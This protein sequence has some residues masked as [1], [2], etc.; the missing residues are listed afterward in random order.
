MR[1]VT[2]NVDQITGTSAQFQEMFS[3]YIGANYV[4]TDLLEAD[5][6]YIG[7]LST[8]VIE[9]GEDSITTI[10]E[11]TI[12]TENVVAALVSGESGSFDTLTSNS[13][14]IEYLNSGIIEAGSISVDDLKA[15]LATI[16]TLAADSAFVSYLQNLSSTTAQATITEAYI[17]NAVAGHIS[18]ADL[19]THT[20]SAQQIVLISA[21]GTHPAIA[22]QNAT[23]QFY[24]DDG[25][26]RV[27]IGQDSNGDFNFIVRGS[28][29]TTALFNEN[30]IT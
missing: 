30:G 14:F 3:Q 20:A 23:Q 11:G 8:K 29:G 13:A 27:Q 16:D 6:A 7:Q 18:V 2:I 9:V 1:A 25:N 5:D 15:K 24:D 21:D 28:D 4:A 26:V 22:F 12:T 19:D 17:Y 10:A